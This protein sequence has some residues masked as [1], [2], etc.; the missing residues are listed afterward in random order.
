MGYS[1]SNKYARS[2]IVSGFVSSCIFSPHKCEIFSSE[3]TPDKRITYVKMI[4]FMRPKDKSCHAMIKTKFPVFFFGSKYNTYSASTTHIY[5]YRPR[6]KYEGRYCFHR[7]LSVNISGG[8]GVG[9]VPHPRFG[10]WGRGGYPIPGLDGGGGGTPS[11]VWG[12][13]GGTPARS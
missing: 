8:G 3:N 2:L 1:W 6:T 12:G 4:Y 5:N 13:G 11:Q 7:C 9:G 10:W